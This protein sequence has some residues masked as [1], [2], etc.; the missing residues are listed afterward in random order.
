[1]LETCVMVLAFTIILFYTFD[2]SA[3]DSEQV[4]PLEP[5]PSRTCGLRVPAASGHQRAGGPA[6]FGSRSRQ[7]RCS[8]QD[9]YHRATILAGELAA[10]VSREVAT[11]SKRLLDSPDLPVPMG[12]AGP[13]KFL[14]S[15]PKRKR[16]RP[17]EI[18]EERKR[19]ALAVQGARARAEILYATRCP[20]RGKRRTCR[21]S[22]G[23][24]LK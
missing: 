20:H 18:P 10:A 16:G 8:K 6:I 24:S 15:Q 4:M 22:S 2:T 9:V 3:C 21:P 7:S 19:R 17:E 13:K 23:T 14:D 12:V 11:Q 1:M 5:T